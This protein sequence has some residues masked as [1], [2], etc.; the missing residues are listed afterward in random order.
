M[1]QLSRGPQFNKEKAMQ[2]AGINQYEL[3][4]AG[5]AYARELRKDSHYSTD[6]RH[7]HPVVTALLEIQDGKVDCSQFK[8][9]R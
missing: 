6:V 3:I 8:T 5:A 2:V 4:L 7:T 1:I 9:I